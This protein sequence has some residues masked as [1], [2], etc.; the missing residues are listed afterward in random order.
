MTSRG[1]RAALAAAG[2]LLIGLP[3]FAEPAFLRTSAALDEPRGYCIDIRGQGRTLQL[4]EPLQGHT[5]KISQWDD[6]LIDDARVAAENRLYMPEYDL[7]IAAAAAEPGANLLLGP[8]AGGALES[9]SHSGTGHLV[10]TAAPSLCVTLG[11]GAGINAGGPGYLRRGLALA[12]CEAAAADR[13]TWV[14]APPPG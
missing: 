9:W 7:C 4:A 13:Q 6:M 11:A 1:A 2:V 8:C 10:L 14:F 12:P 5:C 3:A